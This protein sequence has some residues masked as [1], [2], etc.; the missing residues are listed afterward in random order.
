MRKSPQ[1]IKIP[2][3]QFYKNQYVWFQKHGK[4]IDANVTKV[5]TRKKF[6]TVT[7]TWSDKHKY[8]EGAKFHEM[9]AQKVFDIGDKV[10]VNTEGAWRNGE[11]EKFKKNLYVVFYYKNRQRFVNT[12]RAKDLKPR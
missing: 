5:N 4:K 11:V 12:F 9:T 10:K 3:G 2:K 7:Y 8:S 1:K 6:A